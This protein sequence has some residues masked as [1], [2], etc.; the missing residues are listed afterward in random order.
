MIK[1]VTLFY[2]TGSFIQ[3]IV[4]DSLCHI[5][6]LSPLHENYAMYVIC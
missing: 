5:I 4:M 6:R 1:V 3:L 2:N